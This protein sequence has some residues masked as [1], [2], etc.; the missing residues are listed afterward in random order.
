[1]KSKETESERDALRKEEDTCTV[2][3]LVLRWLIGLAI[4]AAFLCGCTACRSKHLLSAGDLAAVATTTDDLT[5]Q[6]QAS[7]DTTTQVTE[8]FTDTTVNVQLTPY[9]DRIVTQD[10]T[11]YLSN[12]YAFSRASILGGLLHHEL[13]IFP[14]NPIPV[15]VPRVRTVT[16]T[17]TIT[18]TRTVTKPKIVKVERTLTAW[19]Q[20]KQDYGGYSLAAHALF[21]LFALCRLGRKLRQRVTTKG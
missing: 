10:T 20:C 16:L 2:A 14:Q 9:H 18:Q 8:A 19:E 11:S 5:A 13:G 7:N 21:L 17:R 4:L 1:M 15:D 12:E 6:V 3:V